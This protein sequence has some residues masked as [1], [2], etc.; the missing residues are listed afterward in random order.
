MGLEIGQNLTNKLGPRFKANDSQASKL[1]EELTSSNQI[2]SE[3]Q[4]N[5]NISDNLSLSVV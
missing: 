5:L 1:Q 4:N 2:N 3:E